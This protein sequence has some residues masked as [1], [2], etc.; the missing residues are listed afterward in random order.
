M[1]HL[2]A[3]GYDDMGRATQV[4]DEIAR[5]GER[6]CLVLLDTAVAVRYPDGCATLNGEPFVPAVKLRSHTVAG[7][8]AGLALGAPPL[9]GAAVGALLR[10]IGATS[11]DVGIGEGFVSEMEGLLKPETSA[12]F[13]L[14]Q[15]GDMDALLRGIRGLGGTVLKTTDDP[16][17]A[18]LIQSTLAVAASDG[19]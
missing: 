18:K 2:W 14:D 1:S 11:D 15:E 10:G 4:R 9:T 8:L 16:E 12:L 6:H 19:R 7:F 3:V 5:L 17:R 13:V